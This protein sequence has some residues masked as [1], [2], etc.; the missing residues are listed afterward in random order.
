MKDYF[1]KKIYSKKR[2]WAMDTDI[3]KSPIDES[4]NDLF[5]ILFQE[6]HFKIIEK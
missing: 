1:N 5:S 4:W 3:K 2:I 6:K